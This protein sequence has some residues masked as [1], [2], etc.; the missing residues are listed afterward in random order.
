M[1]IG[2][3]S[4]CDISVFSDYLDEESKNNMIF[5]DSKAPAVNTLIL[6]LLSKGHQISIFTLHNINGEFHLYGKQLKVHIVG[7]YSRYPGK[8]IYGSWI[9]AFRIK[10]LIKKNLGEIDIL[11]AHWTYEY[12]W[13]AGKFSH[14]LPVVCTVRDWAP[15]IW[16]LLNLKDRIGY[17]FK[18]FIDIV[19]FKNTKIHFI[20]NSP[21]IAQRI[22]KRW[23]RRVAII[24]NSIKDDYILSNRKKYPKNFKIISIAA[25]NDEGKNI[26]NLLKA[27]KIFNT[28]FPKSE[29]SLVGSHFYEGDIDVERWRDLNL[30]TNVK[31]LGKIRHQYLMNV[32]DNSSLMV[33]PSYEE[34]FGNTLIEAM[35]RKVPVIGGI[36][37]GAVP[38]VLDHGNAGLLCNVRSEESIAE[39]IEYIYLNSKYRNSLVEN[40]SIFLENYRESKI[41]RSYID[42]Y[43]SLL[44]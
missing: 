35:A 39:A 20:A 21:Y 18:Y 6:G 31:L 41:T 26:I 7:G 8:H 10:N 38:F 36:H 40:A 13:S 29:L 11:H 15:R 5:N 1:H 17:T 25:C 44:R 37:S 23:K 19:V 16:K 12:A 4:P 9:N 43:Q 14:L 30:L 32:L 2:I 33:H 27:F 22:A 42:F 28:K 24:P 34:S 3:V